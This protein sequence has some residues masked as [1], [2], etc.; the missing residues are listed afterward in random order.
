MKEWEK[1]GFLSEEAYLECLEAEMESEQLAEFGM[2]FVARGGRAS[3]VGQAWRESKMTE[4]EFGEYLT[5]RFGYETEEQY[6][7]MLREE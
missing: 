2:G 5:E 3:E 4:Q 6:E 7:R 1:E